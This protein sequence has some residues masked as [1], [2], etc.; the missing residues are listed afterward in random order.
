MKLRHMACWEPLGRCPPPARGCVLTGRTRH[1]ALPRN[2]ELIVR[3]LR[4]ASFCQS[5]VN[6]T[7]ACLPSVT[8][9]IRSVVISKF[10]L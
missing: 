8:T 2:M 3:S 7:S 1:R 10:S 4:S 9:S 6:S 5:V